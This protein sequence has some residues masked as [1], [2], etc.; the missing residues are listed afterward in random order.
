MPPYSQQNMHKTLGLGLFGNTSKN[1]SKETR[2][3]S[4]KLQNS[5]ENI[6]F[7]GGGIVLIVIVNSWTKLG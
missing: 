7:R 5:L 1:V 4:V 3:L 6:F 2:A